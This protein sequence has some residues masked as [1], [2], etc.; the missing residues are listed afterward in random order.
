MRLYPFGSTCFNA[1][2]R[3]DS[4][5][6]D[7]HERLVPR[8]LGQLCLWFLHFGPIIF[9]LVF[10]FICT[11]TLFYMHLY[12]TFALQQPDV[13]VLKKLKFWFRVKFV[14]FVAKDLF[15]KNWLLEPQRGGNIIWCCL[16][17]TTRALHR[18][19]RISSRRHPTNSSPIITINSDQES[20]NSNRFFKMHRAENYFGN[21]LNLQKNF[22][23]YI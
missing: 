20:Y 22:L 1:Y 19:I 7:R 23:F 21:F 14:Y 16:D 12:S 2:V 3:G 4:N 17:E 15:K 13:P 8:P 5:P 6:V 10:G 11:Y 9:K 18:L